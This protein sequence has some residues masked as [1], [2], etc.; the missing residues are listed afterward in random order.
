MDPNTTIPLD[1]MGQQPGLQIYTQLALCFAAAGSESVSDSAIIDNLTKGLEQ[2]ATGFP[3]IAGQVIK[4]NSGKDSSG[5]FKIGQLDRIPRLVVK[6]AR[7]DESVPSMDVLRHARFPF[8]MLDEGVF[9]P[10]NTLPGTSGEV[11]PETL[12]VF[13]V[14]ATFIAG[15]LVLTFL[16]EHNTMDMTG[17]G[18]VMH[19]LSKACRNVPFT[20]DELAVGNL[21]RDNLVPLL[22]GY[23]DHR[24]ASELAHQVMKPASTQPI[25]D[26]M[27][28][29]TQDPLAAKCTW[30]YFAF[31]ATSL[32]ALKSLAT[33]NITS[34]YV[35]TDDVL[36]A[37]IW[38][39]VT[40]ARLPRLNAT[41]K[42]PLTFARAVDVRRYLGISPTYPGLVQN[43]SYNRSTVQQLLEAPLGIVASQ[44]RSEVDP[45]TSTLGHA[46]CAL[47]TLLERTAQK[48]AISIT[49]SLDLGRDIMLSSWAK[50]TSY[51]LDFGLGLGTPEAVR[52]PQF[53]PVESLMYLMPKAPDG[54]ILVAICLRCEDMERLRVDEEFANYGQFIG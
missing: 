48:D 47:A 10:R 40:R 29:T 25:R 50:E 46:T 3:W 9:A 35:S 52:R 2:L 24:L 1:I 54:E 22:D 16:S 13:L 28:E 38:Q 15:G 31:N 18:Q 36:S 17:Q 32:A 6:D 39:S 27:A 26:D 41:A 5:I 19:L 33:R 14:Q 30:A 42:V 7:R 4:V 43:M 21:A 45:Q 53:V 37:F 8:P 49:A 23:D 44:L 12:P 51:H 20:P 34:A 11:V